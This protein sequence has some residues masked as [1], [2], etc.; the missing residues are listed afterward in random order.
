MFNE[1]ETSFIWSCDGCGLAVE[2]PNLDFYRSVGDLKNWQ[3]TREREGGWGHLC[4][5][6]RPKRTTVAEFLARKA[7]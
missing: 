7:K 5:K 1:D 6:C 4:S 2:F 3:F